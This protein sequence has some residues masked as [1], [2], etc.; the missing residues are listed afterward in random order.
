MISEKQVLKKID[1]NTLIEDKPIKED[2]RALEWR[3]DFETLEIQLSE[4]KI[5][6][7][8]TVNAVDA[9][10]TFALGKIFKKLPAD[11]TIFKYIKPNPDRSRRVLGKCLDFDDNL[12]RLVKESED[13]DLHKCVR[14]SEGIRVNIRECEEEPQSG[15][16]Y[17]NGVYY[18][19][20]FW[21]N[22]SYR[23]L[24]AFEPEIECRIPSSQMDKLINA[25]VQT[26]SPEVQIRVEVLS[27]RWEVDKALSEPW[28][29]KDLLL[30]ENSPALLTS[31]NVASS[32]T[33]A[34]SN[35]ENLADRKI[36]DP[37]KRI[38]MLLW[39]ISALLLLQLFK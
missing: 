27:F 22:E 39:A 1:D 35:A 17:P 33:A 13:L 7:N 26:P 18:G 12:Y 16:S 6:T 29:R 8:F 38:T 36:K 2:G 4:V 3:K 10:G 11:E 5:N 9:D 15:E 20:L 32:V 37:L 14:L 31:I 23:E 25:I 21:L 34:L 24:N 28:M 19:S 30:E